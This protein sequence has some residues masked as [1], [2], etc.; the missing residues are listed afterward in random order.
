VIALTGGYSSA[1]T[2]AVASVADRRQIPFLVTTGSADMITEIDW[3]YVF[4]LNQPLSE[5]S[6]A[7]I[8]FLLEVL[9]P[10]S[11]AILYEN[12]VFGRSG[13]VEFS[14]QASEAGWKIVLDEAYEPGTVDFKAL[15]GKAKAAKPDVVYMISY[16][17]E[18]ALL[19]KQARELN[20]TPKV[21]AG[22]GA[23]FTLPE[24]LE[25]AGSAA[26]NVLSASLWTPHVQYPGAKEYYNGYLK[27]FGAETEYHGAEAYASIYVLADALKRSK[28][29]TPQ[30]IREALEK[31]NMMT[32]F[33]PVRFTSY[34]N[35]KQQNAL[36][37][38]L[39]QWQKG[40]LE[41]VWPAII[42]TKPFV[43]P[44]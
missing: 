1:V 40:L 32:A 3:K 29:L 39:V 33:G 34:G 7:L 2:L 23:G 14:E 31:T 44:Q 11:V 27:R 9:K 41:T 17:N 15:L 10:K 36:P 30:G 37:M 4:R 22:A 20:F 8:E 43:S 24:F 19:M 16:V 38:Y 13:A 5:Y 18:A 26:E 28:E 12:G 21:F 6:K 35:M 25:L 42:E